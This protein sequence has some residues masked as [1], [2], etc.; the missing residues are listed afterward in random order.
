MSQAKF[1]F[2]IPPFSAFASGGNV[3]NERLTNAL[4]KA[5][6]EVERVDF[7]Q[8][9]QIATH[10]TD[11]IAILDSLFLDKLNASPDALSA[12][13]KKYLLVHFLPRMFPPDK[14]KFE[15]QE[16]PLLELFD[17]LVVTS[18][19]SKNYF[20][21]KGLQKSIVVVPPACEMSAAVLP[22][23]SLRASRSVHCLLVANLV[24]TKGILPFF[25]AL[26]KA[27]WRGGE[28]LQITLA[29]S[30]NIEPDYAEHCKQFWNSDL[31]LKNI[32]RY[33]GIL[34]HQE[35]AKLYPSTDLFISTSFFETYGMALQE[36]RFFGL[37]ILAIRGGNVAFHV[38]EN[39]NGR[40]F[41]D[42]ENLVA[43]LG[44]LVENEQLLKKFQLAARQLKP[45]ENYSWKVAAAI[46]LRHWVKR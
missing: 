22:S 34:P 31:W 12:F 4:E 46:F 6:I 20:L 29:G 8:L 3:F 5:G 11:R 33:A 44:E 42:P 2:I 26:A 32:T 23:G 30:D 17:G 19:F 14:E 41:S 27:T 45:V 35:L 1:I 24:A 9:D 15:R 7:Q 18:E 38:Q 37:P 16:R 36:A 10:S 40:L 21:E 13:S 28:H 25:Q 43:F 39:Q